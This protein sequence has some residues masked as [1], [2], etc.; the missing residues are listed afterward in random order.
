[1]KNNLD[2]LSIAVGGV[3]A[4]LKAVKARVKFKMIAI[5]VIVGAILGYGTIGIL[6]WVLEDVS[7]NIVVLVTFSVGWTANE[8]TDVLEKAVKD[9]YDLAKHLKGVKKDEI[10][11]K[12]SEKEKG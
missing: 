10:Q 2:L 8:I 1:M 11:S 12:D 4:F 5:S 6:S 9:G 3:G 7:I